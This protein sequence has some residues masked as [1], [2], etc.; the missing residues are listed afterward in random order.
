MILRQ[1][2]FS[3]AIVLL[4]AGCENTPPPTQT[5]YRTVQP[6]PSQ[7]CDTTSLAE[8]K[9]STEAIVRGAQAQAS[10]AGATNQAAKL[11]RYTADFEI[12]HQSM[13]RSCRIYANC[14]N[15][16]GA[17]EMRCMRSEQRWAEAE[18]RYYDLLMQRDR[19]IASVK[20]ST[21]KASATASPGASQNT[22]V[23]VVQNC[24]AKDCPR[25]CDDCEGTC[26]DRKCPK[27]CRKA[28][29]TTANIFTDSCCP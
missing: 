25:K 28:C 13:V 15:T 10:S 6:T 17:N 23:N 18:R 1:L 9:T 14:L 29:P 8:E 7:I 11:K 16:N 22:V 4:V 27:P 12:A 26:P 2:L 3:I 19:L 20:K 21:K 24:G 5:L